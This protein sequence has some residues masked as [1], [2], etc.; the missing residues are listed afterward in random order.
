TK[1]PSITSTWTR[2]APPCSLSTTCSPS[3]AKSA[4]RID[5]ATTTIG[6]SLRYATLP[7]TPCSGEGRARRLRPCPEVEADDAGND[8]FDR[9]H[10]EAQL[11]RDVLE[12]EDVDDGVD[13]QAEHGDQREPRLDVLEPERQLRPREPVDN[14]GGDVADDEA[15]EE[16]Q[17]QE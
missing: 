13:R 17:G 1:W 3:R 5:G 8:C 16:H 9:G 15:G 7:A 4:D 10:V 14:L 11:L 2:F 12:D 6:I